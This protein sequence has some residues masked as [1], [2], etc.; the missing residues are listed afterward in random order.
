MYFVPET[1]LQLYRI[2]RHVWRNIY[3]LQHREQGTHVTCCAKPPPAAPL[4]LVV[5]TFDIH[6]CWVPRANNE[7]N[8]SLYM[9]GSMFRLSWC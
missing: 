2:W 8:V 3:C 9:R 4:R 7:P 6:T 5:G 1:E